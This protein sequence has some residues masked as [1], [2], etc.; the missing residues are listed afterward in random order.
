MSENSCEGI[1]RGFDYELPENPAL[2][3]QTLEQAGFSSSELTPDD[4]KR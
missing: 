3:A 1:A 4:L 2:Y